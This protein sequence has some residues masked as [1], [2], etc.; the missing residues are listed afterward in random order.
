MNQKKAT[1]ELVAVIDG[2][3]IKSNDNDSRSFEAMITTV[4]SPNNI[5]TID[6]HHNEIIQKTSV[7][8]AINDHQQIIKKL[9]LNAC[10]KEGMNARVTKL[11]CLTDGASNCW[12]ITHS[13]KPYCKELINV[14]DWFH[15]TKRFTIINN[16]VDAVF[17]EKLEK[18][19]WFL[20]HGKAKE[21]LERLKQ[22]QCKVED[23]ALL[24]VLQDLYKY[25]ERNQ[26]YMVNY[27]E[28]QLTHLPFT[29][30]YAE[31]SVNALINTRQKSNKKMQWSREGAHNIL[32]IRASLFSQ[33]WETDWL[34]VQGEIYKKA[35]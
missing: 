30:T 11:T 16:R 22:L 31:V 32:Q 35:A 9:T 4:Y 18:V 8:S 5:R 12:S 15:I 34:Q 10:R 21:G 23:E 3:H 13:L 27:Q 25:L 1:K 6:K 19:K 24:N 17:K 28:R 20:W 33:T 7:A 14:L 2:G 26:K 29:S